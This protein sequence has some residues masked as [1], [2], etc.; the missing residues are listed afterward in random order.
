MPRTRRF[1]GRLYQPQNLPSRGLPDDAD[2]WI[3]ALKAGA[4]EFLF[5]DQ[6]LYASAALRGV[7][8]ARE[9]YETW[10][11]ERDAGAT[12]ETEWMVS[13]AVK[14][15][16]RGRHPA[17]VALWR[18]CEGAARDA[19]SAP[20]VVCPAGPRL[21]FRAV[22]HE[23]RNYL[24]CRLPSSRF[25]VYFDP[26]LAEDG[27]LSYMGVNQITRQWSR[28]GTFGGKFVENAAQSVARDVLCHSM[29][30]A[31]AEGYPIVLT[32]HDELVA[33]TADGTGEALAAI[34]SR[35]PPWAEGLPLSAEGETM[36]RYR[37]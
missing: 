22:G 3:D 33:E 6:M 16:W 7:I 24:L 2:L 15:A 4:H 25:L 35:V 20:G 36:E 1:A 12:D 11:H 8:V 23:G 13:E 26:A 21:A 5:D 37:K 27:S 14:V 17:T 31:E 9:N 28:V 18:A 29:P 10:G 30:A 34:M 32:V 19:L